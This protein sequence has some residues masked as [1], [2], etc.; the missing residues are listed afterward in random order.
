M[1]TGRKL[2]HRA[3]GV[4]P[5]L[6]GLMAAMPGYA[7]DASGDAAK[8]LW[9][10]ESLTDN[11][12]G[13]ATALADHGVTLGVSEVAEALANTSGGQ[14]TGA[15]FTGR[16]EFDLDLDLAKLAGWKSA[17]VHVNA[18]Q[19]HGRGLTADTLG[20]NLFDPSNIE[21]S[22]ATRLFD[23]YLEQSLF[24]DTL[25]L[26]LG[27][28]AADDEF[29]TSDYASA[30]INGTFG[31]AGIMAADLPSGGPAYPLAT[32]GL[33]VKWQPSKSFYW[34]TAVFNGDPAGNCDG[35]PQ[36]CN[37]DGLTFAT[38]KDALVLSEAG[39]SFAGDH[40]T[41]VKLGGW[42]HSGLFG[43]L[44]FDSHG[45][46]MAIS[47]DD[48]CARRGNYGFYAAADSQL[49]R[50]DGSETKGLGAFLRIGAAPGDRNL[51]PFYID[52]GFAYT[53]LIDGRDSDVLGFGFAFAKISD[54]AR[55][56]DRDCNEANPAATRPVRDYEAALEISYS[57][58]AAP[59]WTIQPDVQYIIHPAGH[60]AD[61]NADTDQPA[62]AMNNAFVVGVRT[63]IHL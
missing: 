62:A 53:G 13:V 21:A 1:T 20:G 24:D 27:Q 11:W 8:G 18:F 28:L 52:T 6:A 46:L 25:S 23:A 16:A 30:L 29:L 34:Q 35:D 54:R 51:V 43:D 19:I 2:L 60:S 10:R 49:W 32:P 12:N 17:T 5:I 31:W 40:P 56:Y 22:R 50:Q 45:G 26:R 58:V 63:A 3:L 33:R 38:N 37:H 55:G 57:Y 41:T 4:L 44:R 59:W 7:Q 48:P 39:Y 9:A 15:V 14:T 47:G 61:P 42:Y 36:L